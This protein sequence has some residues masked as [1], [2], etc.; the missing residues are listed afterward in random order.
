M[1][2]KE[3]VIAIRLP[4]DVY[5][6]LEQRAR[7]LGYS[8][9]SD[10]LRDLI[11]RELGYKEKEEAVR[12]LVEELVEKKL[13]EKGTT[14]IDVDK[15]LSKIEKKIQDIINPWTAKID[16]LSMRIS[17][18]YEKI[19]ELEEKVKS[20]EAAEAT[21]REQYAQAV[22]RYRPQSESRREP[23]RRTAIERLR[24][25]GA[26]FEHDVQWLR[27]RDAFFERLRREGAIIL[28][29]GGE[30]IAVDPEFWRN[31]K[32]KVEQLPTPNDD[33]VR[34][35]LTDTQ[36]QL[37]KKLKE[38][39]MIYFDASKRAWRFVEELA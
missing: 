26:V 11:Y 3:R 32:E 19:E 33:E 36:Y 2:R 24:E 12:K 22:A 10:Y 17:E 38:S 9:V 31:F 27:D 6:E 20:F 25:Q 5:R 35:L 29:V 23:R 4:S 39:G 37:F 34:V 15:I 28:N 16:Q 18:L 8:L 13:A 30:R 14:E 1:A 7:R 21:R